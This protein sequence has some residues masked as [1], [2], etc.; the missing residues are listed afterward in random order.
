MLKKINSDAPIVCKRSIL[1]HAP[2]QAVYLV[3][4]EIRQWPSWQPEISSVVCNNPVL[5]GTGFRW[6]SGGS[7]IR[8]VMHTVSPYHA[9]GWSGKAMG[10]FA[11]HNW[12][13]QES[14][15]STMVNVEESMEGILAKI[16]KRTIHKKL[17]K[18]MENW[19]QFLK[20]H[21]EQMA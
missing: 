16:L 7:S 19:L 11:I 10:I 6:K 15:G 21:C 5:A 4:A 18:G 13:F 2:L 12:S 20:H 1:V 8:S 17:A 14:N 3:M 9:L